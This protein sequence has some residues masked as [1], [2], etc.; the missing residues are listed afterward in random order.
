VLREGEAVAYLERSGR[1]LVT[2]PAAREDDEWL[3]AFTQLLDG[4]R[5]RQIELAKI[6]GEVAVDSPLAARL[7]SA[8]FRDGYRGL[9]LR[10]ER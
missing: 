4:G 10:S 5:Y 7:R 2:F 1:S 3:R 8:G 6:D 9:V